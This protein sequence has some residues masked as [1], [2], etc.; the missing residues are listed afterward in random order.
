MSEIIVFCL[1]C[2]IKSK[3]N[4]TER[5][6]RFYC[7]LLVVSLS[8]KVCEEILVNLKKLQKFNNPHN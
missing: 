8:L 5:P 3:A 2:L 4:F 6:E 7:P 1:R